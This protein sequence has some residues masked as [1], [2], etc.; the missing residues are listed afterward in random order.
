[1]AQ[2]SPSIPDLTRLTPEANRGLALLLEA[3]QAA[4]AVNQAPLDFALA[5]WELRDAGLTTIGLR[6]LHCQGCLQIHRHP[7]PRGP[8]SPSA[9]ST[10]L[11]ITRHSAFA[12]TRTGAESVKALL[13]LDPAL[14]P[15]P[16]G[17][18]PLAAAHTSATAPGL[19]GGTE[20]EGGAT[21]L[22]AA[23]TSAIPHFDSDRRELT[24]RGLLVKRY[25]EPAPNQ[26][27]I[28]EEFEEQRWPPCIQNPLRARP[29]QVPAQQFH[30]TL[31]RLNQQE[32]RLLRFRGDGTGTGILWEA[33]VERRPKPWRKRGGG[34]EMSAG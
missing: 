21:P 10:R 19:A 1:M 24:F 17:A 15:I 3:Y 16:E 20:G 32:H 29:D 23:H 33:V 9:S 31:R 34:E 14:T 6:W 18:T 30:D 22:A 7:V 25:R 11:P 4:R 13:H 5:L 27:R 8:R 12:L 2:S 26:E 28:L